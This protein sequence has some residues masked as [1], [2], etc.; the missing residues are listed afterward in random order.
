MRYTVSGVIRGS[1]GHR[2]RN[3]YTA[4]KC[5]IRDRSGCASQGGFSD[6][7]V[8]RSNGDELTGEERQTLELLEYG[9]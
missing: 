4:L 6:R 8:T 3:L 2:H 7:W 1:C 5:L 9:K